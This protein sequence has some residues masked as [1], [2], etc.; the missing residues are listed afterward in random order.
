[1]DIE[2]Y[3][4]TRII[5]K[6]TSVIPLRINAFHIHVRTYVLAM[7]IASSTNL[8]DSDNDLPLSVIAI[9]MSQTLSVQLVQYSTVVTA[10]QLK[11]WVIEWFIESKGRASHH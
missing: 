10:I 8:C 3:G 1:M 9:S 6:K 4:A 5:T 2:S 7:A 11:N